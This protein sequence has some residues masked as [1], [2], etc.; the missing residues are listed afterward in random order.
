MK[1]VRTLVHDAHISHLVV[2]STKKIVRSFQDNVQL[3]T[4]LAFVAGSVNSVAFVQFGTYVSHVSGHATRAAI[5]YAQ[6]D[7]TS[8]FLFLMEFLCF[9]LGAAATAFLLKGETAASVRIKYTVPIF[10]ELGLILLF[11]VGVLLHRNRPFEGHYFSHLTFL[12]AIAMG[13][14]NAML[15]QASGT[16]IRTTH[17]T[18]VATDFG[19]EVGTALRHGGGVFWT[20]ERNV[21]MAM[22]EGLRAFMSRLGVSRFLF[23]GFIILSF[24]SGAVVGTLG[25]LMAESYVLLIPIC[26]LLVVG[27]QEYRRNPQK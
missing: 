14:Q 12:L 15:R 2:H 6:G 1:P 27:I 7:L 19:V 21:L 11:M 5:D 10:L 16:L 24:S 13:M 22:Y 23:H 18:G 4:L 26:T 3:G 9:I 17:M 8:A 20:S 25:F